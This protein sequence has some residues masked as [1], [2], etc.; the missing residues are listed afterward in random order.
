M[1]GLVWDRLFSVGLGRDHGCSSSFLYG[2]PD[3]V[4][5]LALI[6]LEDAGRWQFTIDQRV[7]ALDVGDLGAGHFCSGKVAVSVGNAVE[8]GREAAF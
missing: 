7:E 5:V 8:F 4:A 2:V 1:N 6:S 3:V